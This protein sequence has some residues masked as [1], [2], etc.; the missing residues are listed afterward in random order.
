MLNTIGGSK[1]S[2]DF[3]LLFKDERCGRGWRVAMVMDSGVTCTPA[4][5]ASWGAQGSKG[6]QNLTLQG[7]QMFSVTPL[8]MGWL[9]QHCQILGS[10]PCAKKVESQCRRSDKICRDLNSAHCCDVEIWRSKNTLNLDRCSKLRDPS[11]ISLV[12]LLRTT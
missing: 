9:Y 10:K 3:E 1:G 11:P 2:L 8:V 4:T 7:A 12:L 5:T 6:A